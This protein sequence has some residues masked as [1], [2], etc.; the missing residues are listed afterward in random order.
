MQADWDK[1][2]R[3]HTPDNYRCFDVPMLVGLQ[4]KLNDILIARIPV[5]RFLLLGMGS[6][7]DQTLGAAAV[8]QFTQ[9]RDLIQHCLTKLA[10]SFSKT[11]LDAYVRICTPEIVCDSSRWYDKD[12][13][14]VKSAMCSGALEHCAF[15]YAPLGH[16]LGL[17]DSLSVFVLIFRPDN[18]VRQMLVDMV[19]QSTAIPRAI[20]CA[21]AAMDLPSR[22]DG[23]FEPDLSSET[24]VGAF[25]A[26]YGD[27][28]ECIGF[29]DLAPGITPWLYVS[30]VRGLRG[31]VQDM[32]GSSSQS[33]RGHESEDMEDVTTTPPSESKVA[34][35]AMSMIVE[36]SSQAGETGESG[37]S[38]ASAPEGRSWWELPE[39]GNDYLYEA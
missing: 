4:D 32:S 34:E 37:Q 13:A 7:H 21:N 6:P 9:A 15:K 23:V 8:S 19:S 10:L 27:G 5:S 36:V 28:V 39:S 30:K 12:V 29:P 25:E 24:V 11:D 22:Y 38:V 1:F 18:L 33:P 35:S 31:G 3:E 26:D 16:V 17:V 20:L 2:E 14:F